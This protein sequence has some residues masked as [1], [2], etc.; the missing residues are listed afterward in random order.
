[1]SS[2]ASRDGR[3]GFDHVYPAIGRTLAGTL[4]L[5]E[6]IGPLA[7]SVRGVLPFDGMGLSLL[8]ENGRVHV[9][10]IGADLSGDVRQDER[11]RSD[12]S[13]QLWP[14]EGDVLISDAPSQLDARVV[15]DRG[16]LADGVR[17]IAAVTIEGKE[18]PLGLLWFESRQRGAF[19]AADVNA[20]RPLA[21][22]LVLAV[23]HD[24]LWTIERDRRLRH[25]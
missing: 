23:E 13:L 22:L 12:F 25:E 6:V 3:A 20:L 7:A 21:E 8:R 15:V 19:D 17:A 11:L 10:S 4:Q 18:R 24:R 14:V 16:K 2:S 1:M 5:R 9:L